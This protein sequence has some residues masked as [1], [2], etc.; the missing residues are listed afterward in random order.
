MLIGLATN[1]TMMFVIASQ[2]L[3]DALGDVLVMW[4][5]W[6]DP[7]DPENER[8]DKQGA[9]LISFCAIVSC[10]YVI[11]STLMKLIS[12]SHPQFQILGLIVSVIDFI[13]AGSLAFIKFRLA[14]R[15]RSQ[16]LFLDA[17]T[18]AFISTLALFY[19]F[20]E[21][22][23]HFVWDW[24]AVEHVASLCVG[25][26]FIIYAAYN[27][28]KQQHNGHKWYSAKFWNLGLL[29]PEWVEKRRRKSMEENERRKSTE[30]N[31]LRKS[32]EE[33]EQ[34]VPDNDDFNATTR[35]APM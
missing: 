13:F 14:G 23:L 12:Q 31:D 32:T 2:H 26:V 35:S 19:I 8:Y 16:T 10:L 15:L 29:I 20:S 18:S 27:L 9:V 22:M 5:F 34:T 6:C 17:L 25:S 21:L 3:L 4:R 11:M 1:S 33:N 24:W 28:H 7:A 30:E